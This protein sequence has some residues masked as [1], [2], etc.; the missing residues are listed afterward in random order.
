MACGTVYVPGSALP[1]FRTGETILWGWLCRSC[2]HEATNRPKVPGDPDRASTAEGMAGGRLPVSPAVVNEP[3][4]P[5]KKS[6]EPPVAVV[7]ESA[8]QLALFEDVPST[9]ERD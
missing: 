7:P 4:S 1:W 6:K 5:A 3:A 9:K 8:P 2:L